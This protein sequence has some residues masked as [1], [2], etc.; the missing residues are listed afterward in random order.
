[1]FESIL[2][3]SD[4]KRDSNFT[5]INNRFEKC[6]VCT[7]SSLDERALLF[8]LASEPEID[9][10]VEIGSF[11]GGSAAFLAEAMRLKGRTKSVFSVDPFMG[12]PVWF[13]RGYMHSTFDEFSRNMESLG[14]S[15]Q[16]V[17]MRGEF[18]A[19]AAIWPAREIDLLFIDGDHSLLGVLSDFEKW[20]PK[21][22]EGGFILIDDID[23][24]GDVTKF[25]G[26]LSSMEGISRL[27]T[28]DGIAVYK[29][30]Q[31][32]SGLLDELLTH[33]NA[34][35]IRRPWHYGGLSEAHTPKR[36]RR[37]Q[38]ANGELELCYELAYF[39]V[40]ESGDYGVTQRV[41]DGMKAV[42]KSVARDKEDGAF[43]E[44]PPREGNRFR[45]CF[46]TLGELTS[47]ISYLQPGAVVLA[48][49]PDLN[50]TADLARTAFAKFGI[51]GL[52]YGSNGNVFWGVFQP[53]SMSP[54]AIISSHFRNADLT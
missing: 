47:C 10:V 3:L 8:R 22:R 23:N 35:N 33:L 53:A 43:L 32:S 28:V 6:G 27:G 25:T 14:V 16:I 49:T 24:I 52:G 38:W 29:R 20:V 51:E 9:T 11:C 15:A 30:N 44:I 46:C 17:P 4:T 26:I 45:V 34:L 48:E 50:A 1:M 54:D 40:A 36:F 37:Q 7:W 41:S 12:A 13:P 2:E 19:V 39:S 42:A 18:A 21:V 31:Q 5:D